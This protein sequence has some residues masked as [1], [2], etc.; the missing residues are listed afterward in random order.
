MSLTIEMTPE[1][2]ERLRQEA[3]KQDLDAGVYARHLIERSLMKQENVHS[4]LTAQDRL[5]A[6][7]EYLA[8]RDSSKPSLPPE[9]FKRSSFYGERG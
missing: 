6:F 1:L 4:P 8:R 9:A 7:E 5:R 2:E 3:E